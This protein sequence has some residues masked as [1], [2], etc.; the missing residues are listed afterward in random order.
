MWQINHLLCICVSLFDIKTS[1]TLGKFNLIIFFSICATV[2][3][4][5]RKLI[6]VKRQLFLYCSHQQPEL[7][8][9]NEPWCLVSRGLVLPDLY[10]LDQQM[11][12]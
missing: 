7:T 1:Y 5:C 3:N 9:H 6:R 4:I 12:L 10:H 2:V 11:A 8:S